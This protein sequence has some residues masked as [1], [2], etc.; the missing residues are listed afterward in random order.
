MIKLLSLKQ[1]QDQIHLGKTCIYLL[2]K[3]GR[4]P[5]PIK[6]GKR[7]LWRSDL[8]DSWILAQGGDQNG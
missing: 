8:I 4:F 7:S 3:D 2:I 5:H 1:V 6:I